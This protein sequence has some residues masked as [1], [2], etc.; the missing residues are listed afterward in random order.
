MG[1]IDRL[2]KPQSQ[3]QQQQTSSPSSPSPNSSSPAVKYPGVNEK[4]ASSNV[5]GKKLPSD[6]NDLPPFVIKAMEHLEKHG[7]N[8]EGIFRISPKKSD[9]EEV[10]RELENNIKFDVPYEKYEIHLAS[11]LL[12]LYLRELCDPLL[13]YEQ[14]GMFI[15]AERI[16]DPEP[17]LMMI[18]KVIKFLPPTNFK[19]MKNLCLFLKRVAAN[20]AVN[21]MS[22]SNLAIVFA[23]NLL[24]SD[25]P[26][27]HMEIL[28]DSKYSNSLM[29][30]LIESAES[31]FMQDDHDMS[32]SSISSQQSS[33]SQQQQQQQQQTTPSSTTT[34]EVSSSPPSSTVRK[35]LPNAHFGNKKPGEGR[36]LPQ[37]P[38]PPPS[39]ST[40]MDSPPVL[41]DPYATQKQ[42]STTQQPA[43]IHPYSEPPVFEIVDFKTGK[44]RQS[45]M[46]PPPVMPNPYVTA[47]QQQQPQTT[48]P[49]VSPSTT[50]ANPFTTS[51]QPTINSQQQS[52]HDSNH[53]EDHEESNCQEETPDEGNSTS[54]SSTTTTRKVKLPVRKRAAFVRDVRKALPNPLAYHSSTN[55]S[56]ND[57]N[58]HTVSSTLT[59]PQNSQNQRLS[60]RKSIGYE[61]DE[62]LVAEDDDE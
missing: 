55:S 56:S 46:T 41:T 33:N 47:K 26:Q 19:I 51:S 35:P 18:Q 7:L 52:I 37:T 58:S 50:P 12:K 6:P 31:I 28:Q 15:A 30:T 49:Q 1:L 3:Q 57:H 25:L 8:V 5:F 27:N 11:S 48:S 45:P 36:R 21:K 42:T 10:I 32:G 43:Q 22:P 44:L 53:D 17:R 24:K 34:L 39:S 9:E 4:Y 60:M 61:S 23:P 62:G 13:T 29:T 59:T 14:Y 16:P 54:S 2:K 20:S 40:W 38:P